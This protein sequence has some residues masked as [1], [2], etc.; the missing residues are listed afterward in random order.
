[1]PPGGARRCARRCGLCRCC[2]P[3]TVCGLRAL[4]AGLDPDDLVKQGGAAAMERL[5][6]EAHSLPDTLWEHERAALQPLDSPEDKAGLKARLLAHVETIADRDIKAMY[7]RDLL[8]RF[9]S[10]AFPLRAPRPFVPQRKFAGG[11]GV[12]RW[13]PPPA[14][15]LPETSARL[16]DPERRAGSA[17]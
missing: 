3:R 11:R 6:S 12:G 1:M 9:S 8:E 10:F 7:R 15:P 17:R 16:A 2:V 14:R 13:R 4:P 5:L